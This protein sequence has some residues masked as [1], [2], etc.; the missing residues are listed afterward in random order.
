MYNLGIYFMSLFIRLVSP[1]KRKARLMIDGH[2]SVFNLL[3]KEIDKKAK[4]I[5]FH[6]ASLGEFEQARPLIEEIKNS[7]PE[8]KILL[9]F[10]SP[11]GYEV[12]YNYPLADIVTY[13][14]FDTKKNARRFLELTNPHMVIFI[15]YEFWYNYINEIYQRRIPVYLVSAIFR[16]NQSFFKKLRSPYR[17]MLSLYT[18][19]FVQ[20]DESHKLLQKHGIKNVTVAGD[21]RI[22]RVIEI[23]KQTVNLPIVE[24]F[25]DK[26]SIIFIAGSSWPA[27]EDIFINYFNSHPNL[28]L[29]I[30]PH[31]ID[32]SHLTEIEK[33]LSRPSQRYSGLTDTD[34]VNADCMIIDCFGLLAS[35]YRYADIGYIGGGFGDG[36]HNLPEA[37][38]YGIPVIFGPNFIKFREA[39]DLIATGGGFT[40]KNRDEFNKL[41][42]SFINEP[43]L[44]EKAGKEAKNYIFSNSGATNTILNHIF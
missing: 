21:T 35:V 41:M 31:E 27:D 25:I 14:P 32:E 30:A 16:K 10:F 7:K 23:Q 6:V 42:E 43:E 19:F 29:I 39:H 22:D 18:H 20:D 26:G 9:T 15:K 4:Y 8:Y 5:W 12:R 36:I 11:S 33:K 13:L 17:N 34:T 1:F 24:K 44:R 28:K 3:E 40:I 37:A 2:K 38:V